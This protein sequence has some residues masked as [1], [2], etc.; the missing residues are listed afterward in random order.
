MNSASKGH[1]QG[2]PAKRAH[3]GVLY[4][5][6]GV[7]KR[8]RWR[9]VAPNNRIVDSS[10]QGFVRRSYARDRL[11]EVGAKYDYIK[12]EVENLDGTKTPLAPKS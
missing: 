6:A 2:S 1:Q 10:S 9:V 5:T 4:R 11:F 8:W 3:R 12:Y 7:I